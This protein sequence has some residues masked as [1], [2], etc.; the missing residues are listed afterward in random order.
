MKMKDIKNVGRGIY[1]T[2]RGVAALFDLV[3]LSGMEIIADKL[4][5]R[6][7]RNLD[8]GQKILDDLNSERAK[9]EKP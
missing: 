4:N 6:A 8:K 2:S 9:E 1:A 7:E 5:A 3:L